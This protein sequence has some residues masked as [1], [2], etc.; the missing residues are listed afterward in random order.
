MS[1]VELGRAAPAATEHDPRGDRLV[2]ACHAHG[3]PRVEA[4]HFGLD[5]YDLLTIDA[6]AAAYERSEVAA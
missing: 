2:T 6:V 4:T 5:S 1:S 3:C